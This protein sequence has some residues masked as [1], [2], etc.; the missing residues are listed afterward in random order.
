MSPTIFFDFD[1]T[2]TRQEV[3]PLIAREIDMEDEIATLTRATMDGLLDFRKSFRLRCRLLS[4]FRS[5][6]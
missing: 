5:A 2:I 1:G 4:Q 6:A 3:L